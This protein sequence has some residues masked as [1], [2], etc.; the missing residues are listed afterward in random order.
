[1]TYWRYRAYDQNRV[2]SSGV[3]RSRSF[4]ELAF[5]LR[6]KGLCVIE[7][8]SISKQE[9][10]AEAKLDKWKKRLDTT[11]M[12]P[13]DGKIHRKWSLIKWIFGSKS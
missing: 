8:S 5:Q 4:V 3:G 12:R 9:A 13:D 2:I 6:Q 11:T 10:L 1:M 7:A